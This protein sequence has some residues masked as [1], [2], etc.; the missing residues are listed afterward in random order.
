MKA[1]KKILTTK[2]AIIVILVVVFIAILIGIISGVCGVAMGYEETVRQASEVKGSNTI[3]NNQIYASRYRDLLNKYLIDKGY[4][5]LERLLFY[6]Q[7]KHNV[8]D[9]TT[10]SDSEWE[11]AYLENLNE[12][13]KQ[14]IPIK[15]ICKKFKNDSSLLEYKVESGL[16]DNGVYI[17]ALNLCVVDGVDITTSNDYSENYPYLPFVFPLQSSFTITSM[18]F[19]SRDVDLGLSGEQKDNVNFHEGWDLAVPTGTNFYSIC[20]GRIL[21]VV[22]TQFNDLPYKESGNSTGNY[23]TV[24][25]D[26]G[27]KAIYYHI[28]ANSVP[29][30]KR[31]G[32]PIK[33]GEL[34]GRTSTTG[35]STGPHLHLGLQRVDGTYLDALEYIDFNYKKG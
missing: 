15:T 11:T 9:I 32:F 22:N 29:Y 30:G 23:V 7:R 1:L 8:L 17:E 18:V 25:C 27:M 5:S 2:I 33:E 21:N 35:L 28:Q 10:L 13:E 20:S 24:Q 26:N 31:E 14:M 3:I 4:V 34:L 12:K 16:N 19:E 6:L